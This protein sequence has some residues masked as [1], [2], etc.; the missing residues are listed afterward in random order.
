MLALQLAHRRLFLFPWSPDLSSLLP[1]NL[2]LSAKPPKNILSL[3]NF[4][5]AKDYRKLKM[6]SSSFTFTPPGL[7]FVGEFA[8]VEDDVAAANSQCEA[9]GTF[10]PPHPTP[11][12]FSTL[13]CK[14]LVQVER[15]RRQICRVDET[16]I[17]C[18]PGGSV[19]QTNNK[20][21]GKQK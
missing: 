16:E 4:T 15:F 14:P 7:L 3:N 10:P 2:Y 11:L 18:T 12:T 13:H 1:L 6:P 21:T 20:Q 5:I 9:P 17:L 8:A 19:T